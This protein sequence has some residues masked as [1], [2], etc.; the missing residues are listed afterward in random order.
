LK[1][2]IVNNKEDFRR[3][4][5]T[6]D[7]LIIDDANIHEFEETQ[8]LSIIDNQVNKTIRVLYDSVVK[9]ANI[10]QMIAMNVREFNKV[11]FY[12][13]QPR[14]ARRLLLH[15]P[16]KPFIVNVNIQ[17]LNITNNSINI[18]SNST[19]NN[20]NMEPNNFK[21]HQEDEQRHIVETQKLI[22]DISTGKI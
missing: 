5:L 6:Y 9:K 15:K 7:A 22:Y 1:T 14:F 16:E 20:V 12:L 11:S 21:K 8:L 2:L 10:I 4:N 18:H 3:L 19:N 17:N 13:S